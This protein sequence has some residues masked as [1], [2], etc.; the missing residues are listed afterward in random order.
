MKTSTNKL[1]IF[2]VFSILT[3]LI[4]TIFLVKEFSLKLLLFFITFMVALNIWMLKFRNTVSHQIWVIPLALLFLYLLKYGS[5]IGISLNYAYGVFY[6]IIAIPLVYS[7][8]SVKLEVGSFQ[9]R[10][11][12]YMIIPLTLS[13]I[14]SRVVYAE[15][16]IFFY[17]LGPIIEYGVRKSIIREETVKIT[18]IMLNVML[19]TVFYCGVFSMILI[20][21]IGSTLRELLKGFRGIMGDYVLRLTSLLLTSLYVM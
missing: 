20:A 8:S 17:I 3:S 2:M 10:S 14:V 15:P 11:L 4:L 12:I 21:L 18:T 16:I 19:V 13:Y 6:T 7:L 5:A 1:S 9:R